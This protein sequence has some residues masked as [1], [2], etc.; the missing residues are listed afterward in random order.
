MSAALLMWL[1]ASTAVFV[2]ANGILKVYAVKGSLGMLAVA[3]VLFTLGNLIMAQVMRG[4]GLGLAIAVSSVFQLL[5]ITGV[6]LVVF[7]ERP[8]GMQMA[9]MALGIVAV[10][11]IAWPQGGTA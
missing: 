1:A 9:G 7:G 6:A 10:A 4:S 3:L 11:L 2:T 8:T 5:A